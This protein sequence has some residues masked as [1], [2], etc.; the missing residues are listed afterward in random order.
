M[1]AEQN[2][3]MK[4]SGLTLKWYSAEKEPTYGLKPE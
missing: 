2:V 4:K 1:A 3:F